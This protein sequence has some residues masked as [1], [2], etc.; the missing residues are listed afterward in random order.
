MTDPVQFLYIKTDTCIYFTER[1]LTSWNNFSTGKYLFDGEPALTTYR[2]DFL[3][4]EK[5]PRVVTKASPDVKYVNQRWELRNVP[6]GVDPKA[7]PETIQW[8]EETFYCHAEE[9]NVHMDEKYHSIKGFYEFTY[10]D[11]YHEYEPVEFEFLM[12]AD[13]PGYKMRINKYSP[14]YTIEDQIANHPALLQDKPC[15]L[16][17]Q[18]SY[19]IIRSYVKMNINPLVS[20]ITSD[21]DFCFTVKKIIELDVPKAY[22][23]DINNNNWGQKRKR[24]P[25]IVTRYRTSRE[26]TVFECAPRINGS[27]HGSYTECVKFSGENME[28]LENNISTYLLALIADINEPIKDC[29]HCKGMGVIIKEA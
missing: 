22:T 17:S 25:K 3:E 18:Q 5:I 15:E 24:K 12:L 14:I 19:A 8:T 6:E 13:S 2:K 16:D 10:D 26:V 9:Y 28:D 4:L 1:G 29:P 21:Y 23:V 11:K 27:V 20:Q 7:F